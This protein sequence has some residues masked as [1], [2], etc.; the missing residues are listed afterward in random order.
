MRTTTFNHTQKGTKR[1]V[2][3]YDVPVNQVL[4]DGTELLAMPIAKQVEKMLNLALAIGV[5]RVE[6]WFAEKPKN[7]KKA[8]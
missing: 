5:P 8:A 4:P 1:T 2:I 6:L 3:I 7:S